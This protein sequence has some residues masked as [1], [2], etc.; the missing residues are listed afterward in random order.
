MGVIPYTAPNFI[1]LVVVRS[2]LGALEGFA[3]CNPLIPDYIKSE[4]R[5]TAISIRASAFLIG[6]LF[7][8][9]FLFG[10]APLD[11]K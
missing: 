7:N 8:I 11:V 1:V 9:I 6:E 2:I 5:G 4:Y 10:K 3:S